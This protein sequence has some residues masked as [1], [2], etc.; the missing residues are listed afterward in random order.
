MQCFFVIYYKL[1]TGVREYF[2]LKLLQNFFLISH[3]SLA[4]V[5]IAISVPSKAQLGFETGL[6]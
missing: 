1:H 5:H 3:T 4:K 6:E 2:I